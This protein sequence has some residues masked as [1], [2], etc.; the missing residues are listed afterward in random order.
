MLATRGQVVGNTLNALP[1]RATANV[2]FYIFPR[3]SIVAIERTLSKVVTDPTVNI[4]VQAPSP[5]QSPASPSGA[6]VV[7]AVSANVN[8]RY[9]GLDVVLD[10]SAD[11]CG[12][13]YFHNVGVW[14]SPN[15]SEPHGSSAHDSN[16]RWRRFENRQRVI[17]GSAC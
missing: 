11:A 5:V 2:N 13:W 8:E 14:V 3:V 7:A 4:T 15:F 9:P 16:E 12:S 1:K 17:S 6:G 10:I